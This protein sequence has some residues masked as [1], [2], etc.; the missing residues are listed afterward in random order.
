MPELTDEERSA[1]TVMTG[2]HNTP[3]RISYAKIFSPEK[4]DLSGKDEYSC[5]VLI[6]KSDTKT[7]NAFKT[8]IKLAI[9]ARLVTRS[10]GGFE[11]LCVP[12]IKKETGAYRPAHSRELPL[13]AITT[14]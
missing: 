14:L 11:S 13:M 2:D 7:V 5:M 1:M 8:A 6:P 3:A 9:N 12:G 4:N 10:L